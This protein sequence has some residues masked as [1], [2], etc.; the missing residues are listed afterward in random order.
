MANGVPNPH[1]EMHI[2]APVVH[3]RVWWIMETQKDPACT[4]VTLKDKCTFLQSI[5]IVGYKCH[6]SS[7]LHT[8]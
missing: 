6:E 4:S 7:D 3:V 5:L 2:K 1:V 8:K